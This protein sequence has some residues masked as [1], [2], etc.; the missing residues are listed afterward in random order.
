MRPIVETKRIVLEFTRLYY[1]PRICFS[2]NLTLIGFRN[3]NMRIWKR[4]WNF[5]EYPGY[6]PFRKRKS[7]KA[8]KNFS[9]TCVRIRVMPSF[10]LSV[11][12]GPLM[13]NAV[14]PT[15]ESFIIHPSIDYVFMFKGLLTMNAVA[16]GIHLSSEKRNV[17]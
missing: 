7:L 6:D 1:S 2:F 17:T 13:S 10:D 9:Y 3:G 15:H 11:F 14:I 4:K 5:I 8:L 12:A 16:L